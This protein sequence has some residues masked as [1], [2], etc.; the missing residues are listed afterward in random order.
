[1]NGELLSDK[2][3]KGTTLSPFCFLFA[4]PSLLRADLQGNTVYDTSGET[5]TDGK[6]DDDTCDDED[7]DDGS[8]PDQTGLIADSGTQ[9]DEDYGWVAW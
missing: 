1:M 7:E 6:I 4:I 3:Q 9:D 8:L 5:S 2:A